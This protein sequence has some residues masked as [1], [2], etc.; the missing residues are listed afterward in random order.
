MEDD[1]GNF[2]GSIWKTEAVKLED[3]GGPVLPIYQALEGGLQPVVRVATYLRAEAEV[4][5]VI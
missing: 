5:S 2:L 4:V 1:S 3:R